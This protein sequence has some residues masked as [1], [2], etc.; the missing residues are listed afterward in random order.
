MRILNFKLIWLRSKFRQQ[1]SPRLAT[2]LMKRWGIITQQISKSIAITY[3]SQP[4]TR[5]DG[6]R[7][8]IN[9]QQEAFDPAFRRLTTS[10]NKRGTTIRL[11]EDFPQYWT[12]RGSDPV[13]ASLR[14]EIEARG[15]V[16]SNTFHLAFGADG[17]I[18]YLIKA[19]GISWIRYST[20]SEMRRRRTC[21]QYSTRSI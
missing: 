2:P 19:A 20:H 16:P 1:V 18:L 4:P 12:Q 9:T 10:I 5:W 15:K 21:K 8:A 3:Q 14:E 6:A 13:S 11:F 17:T 7:P